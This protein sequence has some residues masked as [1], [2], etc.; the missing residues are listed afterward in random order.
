MAC[1]DCLNRR[2]FLARAAVAAAAL[3]ALEACGD[4]QIGPTAVSLGTGVTINLADFP[5]LATTGQ[6]VDI[7]QDRAVMRTG[8]ST[9]IGLS[10]IC[11]HEQ[12]EAFVRSN[13][14]ECDCHGSIFSNTGDVI[15]GPN[16]GQ[17][18]RPLDKLNV[19]FN[20][21]AGTLTIA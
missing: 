6:L 11:T 10:R 20:S 8:A 13:R 4:G 16:T 14:I 5:A 19:Q 12:C 21:T 17:S 1:K 2:E 3:T 18:I 7:G 15:R 9:F